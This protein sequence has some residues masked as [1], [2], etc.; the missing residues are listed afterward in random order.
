MTKL[1]T[2]SLALGISP[3]NQTFGGVDWTNSSARIPPNTALAAN[4][5][6]HFQ[7]ITAATASTAAVQPIASDVSQSLPSVCSKNCQQCLTITTPRHMKNAQSF[8]AELMASMLSIV[9]VEVDLS[10]KLR[11]SFQL[12]LL[13]CG[14]ILWECLHH[15]WCLMESACLPSLPHCFI[16]RSSSTACG[17]TSLPSQHM[18][19][20]EGIKNNMSHQKVH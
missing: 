8:L 16:E 12:Y 17:E 2:T 5:D 7:A 19:H 9:S 20:G 13:P 14:H 10:S 4:I 3:H 6:L 18:K 1:S 15:C 11:C